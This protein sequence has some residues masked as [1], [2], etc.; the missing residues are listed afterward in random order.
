MLS[1]RTLNRL[2]QLIGDIASGET[3]TE[4]FFY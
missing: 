2:A 4:V 1:F 3:K